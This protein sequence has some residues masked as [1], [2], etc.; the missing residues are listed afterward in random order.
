M[1]TESVSTQNTE[2]VLEGSSS[3]K[4]SIKTSPYGDT[5][6]V[7]TT[8]A[9]DAQMVP[10]LFINPYAN[11][12]YTN[13]TSE[14]DRMAGMFG[15]PK[16]P[17][18]LRASLYSL[19]T[20]HHR[21]GNDYIRA[22]IEQSLTDTENH[23]SSSP[24]HRPFNIVSVD[25]SVIPRSAVDHIN[26][27]KLALLPA[28]MEEMSITGSA[29]AFPECDNFIYHHGSTPELHATARAYMRGQRFEV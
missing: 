20:D 17:Q 8:S 6:M 21:R 19:F 25:L 15:N 27:P 29:S 18:L 22:Y 3:D 14:I 10:R 12:N 26:M 13:V 4:T 2:L 28:S 16:N 23:S 7:F 1:N 24:Y 11:S 9:D 5:L